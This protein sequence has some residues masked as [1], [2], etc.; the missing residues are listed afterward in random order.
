MVLACYSLST[1]GRQGFSVAKPSVWNSPTTAVVSGHVN[2]LSD[3][4]ARRYSYLL[5]QN[6]LK[7]TIAAAN[8]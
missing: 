2:L 4:R 1:D 8:S 3:A 5:L 7:W 6:V